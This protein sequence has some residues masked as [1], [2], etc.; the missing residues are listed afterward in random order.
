M[1]PSG[2][3]VISTPMPGRAEARP[4]RSGGVPP[5]EEIEDLGGA[6]NFADCLGQRLALFTGQKCAEL[7]LAGKDFVGRLLQDRMALQDAGA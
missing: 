7:L 4:R 6:G 5:G 3:R 2:S 1:T